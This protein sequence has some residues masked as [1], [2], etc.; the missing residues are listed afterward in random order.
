[1]GIALW[2]LATLAL[3]AFLYWLIVVGE[4]TY[5]GRA[6]V[7]FI[8]QRGARFYDE[9]RRG[10]T[11]GDEALLLPRLRAALAGQPAPRVLDVAPGNGRVPLLLAAQPWFGGTV[12]AIDIAPAMLERAR[13][14]LAA[15]GLSDRVCLRVGEAGALP[16]PDASFDLVTSLEALEF[17]P[18]PRRALAEMVRALRPSGVLVVSKFPDGWARALPGKGLTRQGFARLLGQLGMSAPEFREW[19]PGHYELVIARKL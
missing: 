18:R 10:V 8:Y 4:G 15:A 3:L 1:V 9:A 2:L 7:R 5:L 6:A 12:E 13:A 17:F 14:K 19:Q 11:A 16:W